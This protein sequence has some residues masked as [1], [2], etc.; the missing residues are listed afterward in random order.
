M[1]VNHTESRER[2]T[3]VNF[4]NLNFVCL[5]PIFALPVLQ[6][7]PLSSTCHTQRRLV[8]VYVLGLAGESRI[9]SHLDLHH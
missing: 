4:V 8:S 9:P 2:E 7:I 6:D 3:S 1:T 5:L